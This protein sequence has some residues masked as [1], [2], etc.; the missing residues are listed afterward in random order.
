M[1]VRI[2]SAFVE[3]PLRMVGLVLL[4]IQVV[5]AA[6]IVLF[7]GASEHWLLVLSLLGGAAVIAWG[8][9][10]N[11]RDLGGA[12]ALVQFGALPSVFL[13]Y[14]FAGPLGYLALVLW[15]IVFAISVVA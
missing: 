6:L 10:R 3:N 1:Y 8:V 12:G 13:F 9:K 11:D 4:T 15:A 2:H 7:G 5:A 14:V